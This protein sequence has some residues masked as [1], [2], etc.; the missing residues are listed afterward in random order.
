MCICGSVCTC[1]QWEAAKL[2]P[3]DNSAPPR[4]CSP[5]DLQLDSK[6]SRGHG[7]PEVH[8]TD[9]EPPSSSLG[10][11]RKRGGSGVQSGR[12]GLLQLG[13]K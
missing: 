2:V 1:C 11:Q 9:P 13:P 6:H 12:A 4:I 7:G 5:P 3:I 10:S 8:A